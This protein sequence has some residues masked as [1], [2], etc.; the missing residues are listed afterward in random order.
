M[1]SPIDC[2]P[3]FS[4]HFP[5]ENTLKCKASFTIVLFT[6]HH[7]VSIPQCISQVYILQSILGQ[8][9]T[10]PCLLSLKHSYCF[11]CIELI[12]CDWIKMQGNSAVSILSNKF[13][14]LCHCKYGY[15]SSILLNTKIV[16]DG[17]PW[18]KKCGT[19]K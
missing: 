10:G 8:A 5:H 7:L 4:V 14:L 16:T 12:V 15:P 3:S 9:I 2:I 1:K 13:S 11:C 19:Q 6:L 18:K 17:F